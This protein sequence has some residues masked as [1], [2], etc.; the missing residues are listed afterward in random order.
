M[1]ETFGFFFPLE[2]ALLHPHSVFSDSMLEQNANC[3]YA[4]E[5]GGSLKFSTVN[6][7]GSDIAQGEKK[8]ILALVWQM[9]RLHIIN[10]LKKFGDGGEVDE[11][12]MIDWAN[13][14]VK[15]TVILVSSVFHNL[16]LFFVVWGTRLSIAV[17]CP[18][19]S[20]FSFSFLFFFGILLLILNLA[21]RLCLP[22]QVSSAGKSSKMVDFSDQTL[23]SGRF[24]LD[25]CDAVCP[26]IVNYEI[27]T[28]G[29]SCESPPSFAPSNSP[30]PPFAMH[31]C[32]PFCR[33]GL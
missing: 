32:P 14:K 20:R 4:V 25:L 23:S 27:V 2:G 3:S 16:S 8:L 33:T 9:M 19:L 26:G 12:K 24:L 15:I 30:E 7:G 29:A 18:V 5:V 31:S 21:S 13:R 11:R 10:L 1:E 6:I 28:S 22:P 17:Y